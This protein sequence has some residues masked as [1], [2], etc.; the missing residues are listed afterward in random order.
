MSFE[1][2]FDDKEVKKFFKN[3]D[4]KLSEVKDGKKKYVGLLSAI[5]YG[6]VMDHFEQE[7]GEKGAW[8][9]WSSIYAEH[10]KRRGDAN[11]KILQRSPARLKQNFKP[12]S[13]KIKS[14]GF[15]WFNDAKTK[16]NFP[17]A[18]GHNEGDG[19][20]PQRDFMWLSDKAMEKA[21][22]QTLQ[23]MLEEGI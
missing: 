5:V 23:F 4:K 7:K 16:S 11:G 18:W 13:Y 9:A 15:N 6:D 22:V 12:E 21:S 14:K 19:K 17:Y 2:S 1:A 3:L 10:M 8:P 20:L